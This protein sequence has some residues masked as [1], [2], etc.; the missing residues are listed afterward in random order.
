MHLDTLVLIIRVLLVL[1]LVS[2]MKMNNQ[3]LLFLLMLINL[4]SIVLGI[5]QPQ[6]SNYYQV[7]VQIRLYILLGSIVRRK[8]LN[9]NTILTTFKDSR[10]QHY[11]RVINIPL[12]I[13]NPEVTSIL[14]LDMKKIIE[15]SL[16]V[17]V[18]DFPR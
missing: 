11:I 14:V 9:S 1:L 12:L 13:R 6:S 8:N 16:I 2:F 7:V 18:P 4:Y 5:I 17:M 3:Y 10:Y 15:Q